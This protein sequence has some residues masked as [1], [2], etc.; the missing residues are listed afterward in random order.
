MKIHYNDTK[1]GVIQF[2]IIAN[3][4]FVHQLFQAE[5]LWKLQRFALQ[6]CCWGMDWL[7]TGGF[8]SLMPQSHPTTGPIRFLSPVRFLAREAE[9]STRRN[10]TLVLFS[11]SHQATGPIWFDAGVHLWFDRIIR[12]TPHG[13]RAMPVRASNGHRTGISNVFHILRGPCRTC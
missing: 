5:N 4:V 13:S 1:W 9:W 11:W 2:Y 8:P 3:W 10:F 6:A 7:A 12:R